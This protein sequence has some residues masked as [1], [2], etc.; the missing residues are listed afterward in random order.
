MSTFF[1]TW[2]EIAEYI[3]SNKGIKYLDNPSEWLDAFKDVAG[4]SRYIG[5]ENGEGVYFNPTGFY[6]VENWLTEGKNITTGLDG[7]VKSLPSVETIVTDITTGGAV[8]GEVAL[9]TEALGTTIYL[10]AAGWIA[11]G[12]VSLGLG[13]ASYEVAP[14]FWT[15]LSNAIFEPITGEHLTYEETEP[16]LRKKLSTLLSTDENGKI[17]T[18]VEKGMLERM[19]NFIKTHIEGDGYDFAENVIW[20]PFTPTQQYYYANYTETSSYNPQ[21]QRFNLDTKISLTDELIQG[22]I[23]QTHLQMERAGLTDGEPSAVGIVNNLHSLYPNYNNAEFYRIG[24]RYVYVSPTVQGRILTI[25]GY[26]PTGVS[27]H[28]VSVKEHDDNN[29]IWRYLR[30]GVN[31]AQA[32]DDDYG[33]TIDIL[34]ANNQPINYND[35]VFSYKYDFTEQVGVVQDTSSYLLYSLFSLGY[36]PL[37]YYI[38]NS[39][40]VMYTTLDVLNGEFDEYLISNGVEPKGKTPS[41][42]KTIDEGYRDWMHKA[43]TTGQPDK[44]GNNIVKE[45]VPS[46]VP[47]TDEDTEKIIKYG[48]NKDNRSYNDNQDR[49]Q[50]GEDTPDRNPVDA[51]NDSIQDNIKNYNESQ[52]DP[53]TAPE[54]SP[55]P[56]PDY[57]DTPP[58]EPEG[59]TGDTP[60]PPSIGGVTA[61]GMVSVYNPTKQQ[62]IDFSGWLW[63]PSFLDNFLKIF[64]NPMD[65]II[66]LHIMYATPISSGSEH[67][68][69]G[70]LDS[71]ISSKVVTQQYSKLNCGTISVPE[72]FGNATD[73]EPYT[74]VHIYLPFIGIMPLRANDVIGKQIKVEYGIDALTGTCLA[75]ITT[76]K[77]DSEISC[78]T[79]AGNCAVQIPVSGGN[80]A[81]MIKAISGFIVAGAGAIATGNPVLALGA[82][83]SFMSGNTSV[84]HSGAI[85]SNAGACGI[86]KPY[87]IITRKK[88]YDAI[89]YQHYY[90]FPANKHV[91]LSTCRGY[92]QV[93]SCHVESIYRATDNEKQEIESLLKDGIIII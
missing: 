50:S 82:G 38:E 22:V 63:S 56:L 15:D 28:K 8:A 77:D 84:Q 87:L 73:Y 31:Q 39:F 90:G 10:S 70:Y 25:D 2:T 67:I 34:D 55:Q 32:V 68:I 51:V 49:G 35:V 52:T 80:Y 7:G 81:E 13:I 65:A 37:L 57:P 48:I 6:Q 66:G 54:P 83:A 88:P 74:T 26:R 47:L 18:Y 69:A 9:G 4:N 17:I 89:N 29:R 43:K 44:N 36:A 91:K 53:Y 20:S 45:H 58:T 61:S 40:G 86:R 21:E 42:N 71:N 14:H 62:L 85:G 23:H 46:N 75:T 27:D 24:Y 78:Y 1:K 33:Y 11:A 12:A 72:Y 3:E 30:E 19:Y 93:K 16:F 76:I 5:V 79:F 41:N 59:D 92:T 60:E 64:A